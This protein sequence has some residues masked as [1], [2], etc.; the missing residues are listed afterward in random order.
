M[1]D[2]IY[3][4]NNRRVRPEKEEVAKG[5]SLLA[6]WQV[7]DYLAFIKTHARGTSSIEVDRILSS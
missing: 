6:F 1:T 7:I 3:F 4:D 2:W 5:A